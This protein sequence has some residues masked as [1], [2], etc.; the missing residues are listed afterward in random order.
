[1]KARPLALV[2][3]A[4][5]L[6]FTV[7]PD[8]VLANSPTVSTDE[9]GYSPGETV[10]ITG[11]GF[12]PAG[13]LTVNVTWPFPD[14]RIDAA[15]VSTDSS[16]GFVYGYP[17]PSDSVS[18]I[19][20]VDVVD[21]TGAILA[22]TTFRDSHFRFGHITW[23]RT[24]GNEVEFTV[25]TAWVS[26]PF[27]RLF[28]GDGSLSFVD[29]SQSQ[30][31][32]IAS[33]SG[34][35][36]WRY[37]V[38]HTYS[39]DGPF[40]VSFESCCR[41]STLENA[42][43]GIFRISTVVD[44]SNNNQGSPASSVSVVQQMI[45]GGVNTIALPIGDPDGD[46]YSCRMANG[47][48]SGFPTVAFAGAHLLAVT[49][50]CELTWNTESTT[51]G[52][53]FAVQVMIEEQRGSRTNAVA[54]DFIIEIV[55]GTLNQPPTCTLNGSASNVVAVGQAFSISMTGDDPDGDSLTIN[56]L[57]LPSGGT[58]TPAAETID[59]SP[60]TGTF[61]W[62]PTVASAGSAQAVTVEFTD[63]GGL[64]SSCGFSIQVPAN[65]PPAAVDDAFAIDEDTT[66]NGNVLNGNGNG[67]DSDPDG[68]PLTVNTT[69]VSGPSNGILTLNADGSFS[70]VPSGDFNG[71]DSF[72]Y[73]VD[74]GRGGTDI[75]QVTITVNPVNDAPVADDDSYTAVEDTLLSVSAPGVLDGDTDLDG[76]SLTAVLDNGP[77]NGSLTLNPNGSFTYT[78]NANFCGA[79]GDSFT[80][81]ANDGT[82]DSNV[83]TV[84]ID[85]TCVN[86]AP[87]ANA[88]A[89]TSGVEGAAISL[90]GSGSDV[91]GDT[92]SFLWT[93]AGANVDA[94]A[95]CAFDDYTE[96][97]TTIT[98]TDDGD[99]TATLTVD[100]GK[101]GTHSDDLTV[102]V[103]NVAPTLDNLNVGP[104]LVAVNTP[105]NSDVDFSDPGTNDTHTADWDWGDGNT[106]AGTV[107]QPN[108]TAAN[109]HSYGAPGV[110]TV[111]V[112]VTDDDGDSDSATYDAYVVVYD[113]NAGF[114]TGGG[115]VDSP[116]GAYVA[117]P[118]LTG[119]ATFGFV[120]KYKK[121]ATTPDGQTQFQFNAAG[122]NFHSTSYEWLVVAGAKA[123]YKGEGTINGIGNYGFMLSAIDGQVNGGGGSDKFRIKIWDR[124][125]GDA[126]VYD[127]Q[128]GAIDDAEPTTVIGGGSIVVHKGEQT[129]KPASVD[130]ESG[131]AEP[132]LRVL[133]PLLSQ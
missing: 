31:T 56:H 49:S 17:L 89:D 101:G 61:S 20:T 123:Q 68:D 73:Q 45:K 47:A 13:S 66:L 34:Y 99:Y 60:F 32:L 22:S 90:S 110:Y 4:L 46:S 43:D 130:E 15:A 105:V 112:T 30:M 26:S 129:A 35:V 9:E 104:L 119:K 10:V 100:D 80:Y 82:A 118:S 87:V 69:P 85:V 37:T 120:S 65:Q 128:M 63:P 78:P 23:Q 7:L 111:Q 14:G 70:Y 75:G 18:G 21:A 83:A 131:T 59:D 121:G 126:P 116:A 86:D 114:V 91:D 41:I 48:E 98:C 38:R 1:M 122:L 102:T 58:L 51:V 33:G 133:L 132:P 125:N 108:N 93:S 52:D 64:K 28:F 96:D 92:L 109:S 8:T 77:T 84:S 55:D 40:T 103:I 42:P 113:P 36:V 24:T 67:A 2:L 71:T 12:E 6:A 81:H 72:E 115:W 50:D 16:G 29:R 107:D 62:T 5:L 27:T 127:N 88:G 19:Y 74:D 11:T 39:N 44:L 25:T 57:G 117:D 97:A 76:D 94:G 79:T 53:L 106:G 54:L 124:D 3:F 95:T